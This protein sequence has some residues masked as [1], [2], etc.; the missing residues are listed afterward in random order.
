MVCEYLMR[1]IPFIVAHQEMDLIAAESIRHLYL[2]VPPT[3]DPID[4][5][6][7][8]AFANAIKADPDHVAKLRAFAEKHV[9][10]ELKTLQLKQFIQ[11]LAAERI[12]H[13]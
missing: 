5:N 12:P 4:L 8:V 13:L 3:D 9:M 11:Q 10:M 7:V 1:G 6:R 2:E